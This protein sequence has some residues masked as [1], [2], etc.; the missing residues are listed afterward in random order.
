MDDMPRQ[1]PQEWL[2]AMAESEADLAAG[3]L[4]DSETVCRELRERIAR[5][6]AREQSKHSSTVTEI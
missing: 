1:P 6:E 4:V 2:D 5:M 3:R